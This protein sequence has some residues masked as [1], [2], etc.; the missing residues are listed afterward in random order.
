[1][2]TESRSTVI[3]HLVSSYFELPVRV[4]WRDAT[5]MPF[6]DHFAQ[7]RLEFSGLATA[8]MDL[9]QV[10]WL[11]ESVRFVPGLPATV[12]VRGPRVQ[13]S[14]GKAELDRW[15]KRFDLPFRLELGEHG[16]IVHTEIAG[17]PLAKLEA[18]L[19]V[20][21]GWF[22]LQ[23]RRASVLGV[24]NYVAT[25]FRTYLPLP[26]LSGNFQLEAITHEPDVLRLTFTLPDFE[27]PVTPGLLARLQQRLVPTLALPFAAPR[28]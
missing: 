27:E 24:P 19:E 22:V 6:P 10:A 7:A 9:K 25:L 20:V 11:A 15:L 2:P 8:W 17:F 12:V 14:V 16:L 13:I 5:G 28:G 23:P 1:M 4:H 18:R 26:P 3:D 21:N